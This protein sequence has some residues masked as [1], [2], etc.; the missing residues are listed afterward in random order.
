[1]PAEKYVTINPSTT[2]GIYLVD[3][4]D[5]MIRVSSGNIIHADATVYP[6]ITSINGFKLSGDIG[7]DF[8]YG[9]LEPKNY[10]FFND[11][12]VDSDRGFILNTGVRF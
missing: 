2:L 10:F 4:V 8:K 6:E 9:S 7:G 12:L 11:R 5:A 1:M 3:P